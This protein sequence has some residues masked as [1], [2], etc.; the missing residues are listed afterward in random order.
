MFICNERTD[1]RGFVM[2]YGPCEICNVIGPC[3][4][5]PEQLCNH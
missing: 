1:D 5:I 4:D 2:S 3:N